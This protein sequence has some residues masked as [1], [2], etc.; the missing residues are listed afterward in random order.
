MH[1]GKALRLFAHILFLLA[2]CWPCCC[3]CSLSKCLFWISCDMYPPWYKVDI[4][5]CYIFHIGNWCLTNT[6][7]YEVSQSQLK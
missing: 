5:K 1:P 2:V 4:Y 7:E 6:W 3:C